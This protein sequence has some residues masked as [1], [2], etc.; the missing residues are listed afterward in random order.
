[1]TRPAR[2]AR[3]RLRLLL[4]LGGCFL[5]QA[6]AVPHLAAEAA[7]AG[8]LPQAAAASAGDAAGA[9]NATSAAPGPESRWPM[10]LGLQY[11]FIDQQQ[12]A[13][14]SPYQSHLSLLPAGDRQSTNTIGAYGGWAPVPWGQL[15]LDVE[16][17][18][19]AGV[20]GATGIGGLTNGD[21]V[22]EGTQGLK[23]EFYIARLY[24]RFMLP[25]GSATTA[26]AR[27][28]DQ[29][30]GTEAARRLELK[31]G[32]LSVTDDFD[33]NRYA[34]STRTEFMNWSLWANTAF[35]YAADTRGYTDG[36]VLAYV[37][38]AWSLRYGMYRM[39][40]VANGQTL[41]TLARAREQDLELTLSPPSVSTIVRLLAYSNVGNMGDYE[42]ALAIAA[43]AGAIPDIA[44]DNQ[45]GR[46]KV[47][48]GVNLEQPLADSGDSGIFARLGWNDGQTED[49]VF[50]EVDRVVSFGGQLS[51]V[52]WR[53]SDDR[54]GLAA[55]VEGISGPHRDYLAAGGMGF[56]LGDGRLNYGYEQ[57]VEAYY[58]AQWSWSIAHSPLRL[59]L[60]PDFQYMQN[61]GYNRDRGPVRFYALRVHLEY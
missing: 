29:I 4:L 54:L 10:F 12:T 11:T 30:P 44:A 61:P 39:P 48:F 37:S 18:M 41:E 19:G 14:L 58:K 15:Y 9:A 45:P 36:F 23:K 31:V 50:T 43:A 13:L 25:L 22:R 32:V 21:V 51:G 59:A 3:R 26:V 35:D 60:T 5:W 57:I 6:A 27:G 38:P 7:T 33:K 1:M 55:V 34:G 52:H 56:L 47:G 49:F 17:F 42:E 53:R 40:L 24:A 2:P 28:Q 8:P 46:R 20:S 16:K